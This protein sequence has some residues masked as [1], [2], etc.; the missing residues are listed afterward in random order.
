MCLENDQ[1]E[2]VAM[3][4]LPC[5]GCKGLCCGPVPITREERK[6]I[7]KKLDSMPQK[8]RDALRKQERFYGTCIFYDLDRDRCGIHSARPAV[9]KAFGLYSNMV[10][11]RKPEAA[12]KGLWLRHPS[13]YEGVLSEDFTWKDFA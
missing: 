2:G 13:D 6:R 12:G 5:Q 7:R 1:A 10:C 9:C 8:E 4:Q 11:F 3:E